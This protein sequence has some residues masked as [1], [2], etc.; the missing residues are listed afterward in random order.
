[1]QENLVI[2]RHLVKNFG[3][4][5]NTVTALRG[6]DLEV[7]SGEILMLVGPSGSGKTTLISI[8]AGI[9]TQTSGQCQVLNKEINQLKEEEKTSFRG[10]NIGFVFQSFN[11]IPMFSIVENVSIPLILNGFPKELAFQKAEAILINLG[12]KDKLNAYPLELSGGQQQRV[13]IARGIVHAPRLIVCDEPT[14][15][16]DIETGKKVL[17]LFRENF[18]KEDRALIIVTHDLRILDFADRIVKLEDGKIG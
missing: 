12:L 11:L 2:C 8:I 14:S 7:K 4:K 5:E 16:L 3:E 17:T 10:G 18:L 1:M 9:L 13:A 6:V 15:S